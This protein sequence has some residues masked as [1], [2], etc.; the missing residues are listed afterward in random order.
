MKTFSTVGASDQSAY[1]PFHIVL[2]VFGCRSA[3]IFKTVFVTVGSIYNLQVIFLLL[4]TLT[5]TARKTT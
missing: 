3:L 1:R 4:P 5:L 2:L